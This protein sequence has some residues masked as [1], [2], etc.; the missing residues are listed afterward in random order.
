MVQAQISQHEWLRLKLETRKNIAAIFRIPRSG[1]TEV[2]GQTVVSDGYTYNDLALLTLDKIQEFLGMPKEKDFY[3]LL[4]ILVERLEQPVISIDAPIE[5]KAVEVPNEKHF[6]PGS[7]IEEPKKKG[8]PKK[9][10]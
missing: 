9:V 4:N 10:E 2:V 3:K 5:A 1:G 7:F 6:F 8:R